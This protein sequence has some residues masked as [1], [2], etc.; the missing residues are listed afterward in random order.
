MQKNVKIETNT[1][2]WWVVFVVFIVISFL[3]G[4]SEAEQRNAKK[5]KK[6]VSETS[7]ALGFLASNDS[8]VYGFNVKQ[9]SIYVS[10]KGKDGRPA[11]VW[12]K[13]YTLDVKDALLF[14]NLSFKAMEVLDGY[15]Y[16][17]YN[18]RKD[19]TQILFSKINSDGSIGI[20][21]KASYVPRFSAFDTVEGFSLYGRLYVVVHA[22]SMSTAF[23]M[24]T[25]T[26]NGDLQPWTKLVSPPWNSRGLPPLADK[27]IQVDQTVFANGYFYSFG[28]PV[29]DNEVAF[30]KM[31]PLGYVDSWQSAFSLPA[32]FVVKEAL[33]SGKRIFL[34]GLDN[35]VLIGK[36]DNDGNIYEWK[37][38]SSDV[39]RL[40]Q[41][42]IPTAQDLGIGEALPAQVNWLKEDS[43]ISNVLIDANNSKMVYAYDMKFQRLIKSF[44]G[45]RTWKAAI[46]EDVDLLSIKQVPGTKE[47]FLVLTRNNVFRTTDGG[48]HWKESGTGLP[49]FDFSSMRD[50]GANSLETW[51][52]ELPFRN[53]RIAISESNPKIIYLAL[54][55]A[56]Y[57]SSDSGERWIKRSNGI[58]ASNEGIKAIYVDSI[59]P[60]LAYI[61]INTTV[62]R[63]GGSPHTGVLSTNDG[64]LIWELKECG[65]AKASF[66]SRKEILALATVASLDNMQG[67][68]YVLREQEK[69]EGNA[70][71]GFI[72]DHE[73]TLSKYVDG[74]QEYTYGSDLFRYKGKDLYQKKTHVFSLN[75]N[76]D[77][78]EELYLCTSKG[79]FKTQNGGSSWERIVDVA[80]RQIVF[81]PSDKENGYILR[82]GNL[83]AF[84]KTVKEGGLKLSE[85]EKV[86]KAKCSA[87]HGKN[88]EGTAAAPGFIDNPFIKGE[89][90]PIMEV[91]L[92]GRTRRSL[93]YKEF[94]SLEM[95]KSK[96]SD[97]EA[98]AVVTFV[99]S[100]QG[101]A[102]SG[103]DDE[104]QLSVVETDESEWGKGV[105]KGAVN[106]SGYPS[107]TFVLTLT[108]EEQGSCGSSDYP[109]L[110][111]GG[112]VE[113][114]QVTDEKLILKETISY[115]QK[116]CESSV[117]H[118]KK[119]ENNNLSATFYTL[120]GK[121][122]VSAEL[123]K[124]D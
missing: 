75:V 76:P 101:K 83:V 72:A 26:D 100:L 40:A 117:I 55:G 65:E 34:R 21:R 38:S 113:C 106:Q 92:N 33:P 122:V 107:Y 111:C 73:I 64:G 108:S 121:E 20:L 35:R 47:T 82:N 42:R 95:P 8:F 16:I 60:E 87:C 23:Y 3:G 25:I 99:K 24:T 4:T 109:E 105:W 69:R 74:H 70:F 96:L 30:S 104:T 27:T 2:R 81:F 103:G 19:S 110:S 12:K 102:E 32:D 77:N 48:K 15:L 57:K 84:N 88:G 46:L 56:V 44:D 80:A 39:M 97:E 63:V 6:A 59:N 1:G 67:I 71:S 118:I 112:Q 22:A 9:D 29:N 116:S 37:P 14:K 66:T 45:G 90:A 78:S 68:L 11:G 28:G 10:K 85:G 86:F 17:F 5:E 62:C 49:E 89:S 13:I 94:N 53:Q 93:K 54:P 58:Q 36:I 115:G 123:K 41:R 98:D 124:V 43:L 79:V 120:R 91:I 52:E 31:N 61:E 7:M 50:N 51:F 119:S 114:V 18:G